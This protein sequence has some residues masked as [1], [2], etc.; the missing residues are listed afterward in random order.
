MSFFLIKVHVPHDQIHVKVIVYACASVPSVYVCNW[1]T[2]WRFIIHCRELASLFL[3]HPEMRKTFQTW[4]CLIEDE[5]ECA[6]VSL[7]VCVLLSGVVSVCVCLYACILL[8]KKT[9]LASWHP[10]KSAMVASEQIRTHV[11]DY[12]T[13]TVTMC[14]SYLGCRGGVRG[15]LNAVADPWRRGLRLLAAL[16]SGK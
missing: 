6:L 15:E 10:E 13:H 7:A 12:H 3:F 4:H 1:Q 11:T 2:G 8:F 16:T 5:C 9:R 14:S